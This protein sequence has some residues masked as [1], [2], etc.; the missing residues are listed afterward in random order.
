MNNDAVIVEKNFNA[1]VAKVWKAITNKDQMKQW[2]FD[3]TAFKPEIGFEFSFYGKGKEGETYLHL[4]R[5]TEVIIEKK[6]TYSWHYDGFDGIS[7]VTFELFP[8][9]ENTWLKLTHA[10]LET[11]PAID[12]FAK[13]NFVGGW[14]YLIGTA[15]KDFVEKPEL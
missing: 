10:D 6:L 4:C 3:I 2:Y 13:E 15:L 14:T 7:Y 8:N 11:F 1:P 5:I 9:G 12:A